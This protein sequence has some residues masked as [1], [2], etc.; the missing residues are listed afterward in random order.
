[1]KFERKFVRHMRCIRSPL[2]TLLAWI[3]AWFVPHER[4]FGKFRDESEFE[5]LTEAQH[6]ALRKAELPRRGVQTGRETLLVTEID[7]NKGEDSQSNSRIRIAEGFLQD[8]MLEQNSMATREDCAFDAG[9]LYALEVVPS[10]YTQLFVHPS[11]GVLTAAARCPALNVAAMKPALDF[12]DQRYAL[13][14]DG[15]HFE[16]LYGWALLMKRAVEARREPGG[17]CVSQGDGNDDEVGP[18]T[19]PQI[20]PIFAKISDPKNAHLFSAEAARRAFAHVKPL[21]HDEGGTTELRAEPDTREDGLKQR[22]K[23]IAAR[24][25]WGAGLL[26]LIVF[27]IAVVAIAPMK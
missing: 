27:V 7:E 3:G 22:H 15:S 16:M 18:Q 11:H 26:L 23:R 6:A 9:Y 13:G 21:G 1:M 17:N 5:P 25:L 12:I 2:F 19:P 14:R 4:G 10:G 8:A 20:P 24:L